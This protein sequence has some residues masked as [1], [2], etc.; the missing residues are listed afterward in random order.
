MLVG[1]AAAEPTQAR[2]LVRL[3]AQVRSAQR[4]RKQLAVRTEI[5]DRAQEFLRA[6]VCAAGEQG[7]EMLLEPLKGGAAAG[8]KGAGGDE[9]EEEE[10]APH[11]AMFLLD[12]MGALALGSSRPMRQAATVMLAAVAEGLA[13]TRQE[14][15]R[16]AG[17]AQRRARRESTGGAAKAEAAR[18]ARR[19][20]ELGD[21]L[22]NEV[23]RDILVAKHKDVDPHVRA[24]SIR[25]LGPLVAAAPDVFTATQ[26]IKY[27]GWCLYDRAACVRYWSL[28]LVS[29]MLSQPDVVQRLD[30]FM[31]RFG[32]RIVGSCADADDEVARAAVDATHRMLETE[33]ALEAS[34]E[35]LV[36]RTM[37]SS[38]H[39]GVRSAAA[40]FLLDLMD[41]FSDNLEEARDRAEE[42]G[43]VG[44]SGGAKGKSKGKKKGKGGSKGQS[45]AGSAMAAVQL[46]ARSQLHSILQKAAAVADA[47]KED[48]ARQMDASLLQYASAGTVL[49]FDDAEADEALRTAEADA[50]PSLAD[51]L[52]SGKLAQEAEAAGAGIEDGS[53][54]YPDH[55]QALCKVAAGRAALGARIAATEGELAATGVLD[56][57]L[58][59]EDPPAGAADASDAG[60]EVPVLER[61]SADGPWIER[62]ITDRCAKRMARALP[63]AAVQRLRDRALAPC[64]TDLEP[65]SFFVG[66]LWGRPGAE[67]LCDWDAL[68]AL[69]EDDPCTEEHLEQ[70]QAIQQQAAEEALEAVTARKQQQKKKGKSKKGAIVMEDEDEEEAEVAEGEE[71][72]QE[73]LHEAQREVMQRLLEGN[74]DLARLVP[75]SLSPE[76]VTPVLASDLTGTAARLLRA[77]AEAAAGLLGTASDPAAHARADAGE[78]AR[79]EAGLT[80]VVGAGSAGSGS[81]A[82][83]RDGSVVRRPLGEGDDAAAAGALLVDG[84]SSSAA[85]ATMGGS[86]ESAREVLRRELADDVS[87]MVT[88]TR[89]EVQQQKSAA[90]VGKDTRKALDLQA[91]SAQAWGAGAKADDLGA[92]AA[93]TEALDSVPTAEDSP[94]E[95]SWRDRGRAERRAMSVALGS[96]LPR[97]LQRH[98]EDALVMAQLLRAGLA[99]DPEVYG[100]RG[101]GLGSAFDAVCREVVEAVHR[102]ADGDVLQAAAA[103][104]RH[105][106]GGSGAAAGV[107]ADGDVVRADGSAASSGSSSRMQDDDDDAEDEEADD[108]DEDEEEDE[109]ASGRRGKRRGKGRRG[110]SKASKASAASSSSATGG[111]S[112]ANRRQARAAAAEAAEAALKELAQAAADASELAARAGAA[113]EDAADGG[114]VSAS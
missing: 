48:V 103:L 78:G 20:D 109:E 9:D 82:R 98:S 111:A 94:F 69:L 19:A 100:P 28:H 15:L 97:L 56:G 11:L 54:T 33:Q 70:L 1:A 22:A 88:E 66:S 71:P 104:L 31:R 73:E 40:G 23:H 106:A 86:A 52:I 96:A 47:P 26:V 32:R 75:A 110:T 8:G 101:P 46:H 4:A 79:G 17:D 72:T 41:S 12:W 60:D 44:A 65:T 39:P 77:C 49:Y 18:L 43:E 68:V 13:L 83:R 29:S 102:H 84:T 36:I 30:A 14:L 107:T 58:E 57:H 74:E 34:D 7:A 3:Q 108:E 67:C 25:A 35:H 5:R 85:I 38:P 105:L 64:V 2:A 53:S 92:E 99:V 61:L 10:L 113:A 50:P 112:K 55:L 24:E 62:R 51:A 91:R 45:G 16:L 95:E 93:R 59:P 89:K 63:L 21:L 37:M 80:A 27:A 76:A 42:E 6:A 81:G 114:A 87:K 90:G